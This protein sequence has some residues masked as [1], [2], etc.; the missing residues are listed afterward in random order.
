MTHIPQ[1]A[2]QRLYN[3]TTAIILTRT[4]QNEHHWPTGKHGHH[5]ARPPSNLLIGQSFMTCDID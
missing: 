1:I 4:G 2:E 5:I 3:N